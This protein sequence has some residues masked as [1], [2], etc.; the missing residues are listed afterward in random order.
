[1]F[2]A[3]FTMI[4]IINRQTGMML[5]GLVMYILPIP[6]AA[7]CAKFSWKSGL[8]V[9]AGMCLM[10]VL[11]GDPLT[12][13]YAT[14][15]CLLGLVLGT[16]LYNRTDGTKTL[17]LVM[18]LSMVFSL[19]CTVVLAPLFGFSLTEDLEMMNKMMD[20][21]FD[22]MQKMA[23]QNNQT[24]QIPDAL[25]SQGYFLRMI[26]IAYAFGG[27][28]EGY[29]VYTITI[30]VLKRLRFPVEKPTSLFEFYPPKWTGPAA[31]LLS[32]GYS[33][34][35]LTPFENEILQG[36]VQAAGI[37]A[38]IYLMLFGFLGMILLGRK[39]FHGSK[40]LTILVTILIF[41][42]N[43]LLIIALGALYIATDYHRNYMLGTYQN[44]L[45]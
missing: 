38:S 34:T 27:I 41:V 1:M 18:F 29:I 37:C 40:L 6:L 23:A 5:E 33:M 44:R 8:P 26:I 24:L 42:T 12:I 2:I 36:A 32:L 45:R 20:Q 19:L 4:L 11:F 7:Y 15:E 28:L 22:T 16:C 10:S 25:Q 14:T 30:L 17:I 43:T 31:L 21:V 3:I 9:M 35:T 13:F 39:F